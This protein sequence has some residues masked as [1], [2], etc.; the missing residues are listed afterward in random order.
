MT[1]AIA[2]RP[3]WQL[4]FDKDGDIVDE[5]QA[6][7]LAEGIRAA[8]I[9][10]LVMFSH[11]WNNG[12]TV[13]IELYRRWFT[14]LAE[15]L[16]AERTVGFVGVFW[17]SQLWRDEP[18]PDVQPSSARTDGG[19]A[20]STARAG[21]PPAGPPT[22]DPG[23]LLDLKSMFDAGSEQLDAIAD[24]LTEPAGRETL[25]ELLVELRAFDAATADGTGGDLP[26]SGSFGMLEPGRDAEEIFGT[27]ARGLAA[28]GIAFDSVAGAGQA[29]LGDV[30]TRTLNGAKELLRQLS[31]W[32]MKNRAGVVGRKGL[33]PAV[34]KLAADHP[35]LRVH[36]VGHSFGGRLVANALDG[37]TDETP[38]PIRSITLLQAAFS[39]FAFTEK[40]PFANGGGALAGRLARLDGPLAVCFSSHDS[41]LGTLYPLASLAARDAAAAGDDRLARYRAMGAVGAY[42]ADTL[43]VGAVDAT[44]PFRQHGILNIDAS[45][46]VSEGDPPSGAHSDIFKPELAR[47][48]A[49][50]ARL[51]A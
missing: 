20:A 33:G 49:T 5:R 30:A 45:D 23:V 36:L 34:T 12:R 29:G 24:L 10:D 6:G 39:R 19:G 27:F 42:L 11:G 51:T 21:R 28:T 26:D 25:D 48:V 38:S 47:V 46:I 8:G 40:L 2:G 15:Q 50:A 1:E 18:I 37:I 35:D 9:T 14:L 31:Y 4:V 17:P 43:P 44:Y 22:L 41:A 16:A 13:A 7:A 32:K 3:F